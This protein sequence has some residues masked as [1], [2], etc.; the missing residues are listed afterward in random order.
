M[1]ED[2]LHFPPAYSYGKGSHGS[3][4]VIDV[5]KGGQLLG[6]QDKFNDIKEAQYSSNVREPLGK[7]Y[8]RDY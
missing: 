1:A 4:H 5:M 7:G 6:M 3:E 8:S 2:P